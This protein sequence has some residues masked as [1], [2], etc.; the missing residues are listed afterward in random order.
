[1]TPFQWRH[2]TITALL[3]MTQYNTYIIHSPHHFLRFIPILPL[4]LSHSACVTLSFSPYYEIYFSAQHQ[5]NKMKYSGHLCPVWEKHLRTMTWTNSRQGHTLRK[6]YLF[7]TILQLSLGSCQGI[8]V[9]IPH[10]GCWT[11]LAQRVLSHLVTSP[12]LP[13]IKYS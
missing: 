1:M 7:M 12:F 13:T 6:Q 10:L 8:V 9:L 2:I 4:L 3:P 11:F 5:Q